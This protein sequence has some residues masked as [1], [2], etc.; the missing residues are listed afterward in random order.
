MTN[1]GPPWL[2]RVAS[3]KDGDRFGITKKASNGFTAHDVMLPA[4]ETR[5]D[6][7]P[8]T[9]LIKMSQGDACLMIGKH[10][11][12]ADTRD[13]MFLS[14][15]KCP[16]FLMAHALGR[17]HT[18][19]WDTNIYFI[20]IRKATRLD[21]RPAGFIPTS[22]LVDEFGVLDFPG[23]QDTETRKRNHPRK[24]TQEHVVFG[25]LGYKDETTRSALVSELIRDGLYEIFPTFEVDAN[26]SRSGLYESQVAYRIAGFPAKPK[27]YPAVYS[28][29]NCSLPCDIDLYLLETVRKVDLNR[30]RIPAG[31]DINTIQPPVH[32]VLPCCLSKSVQ[33]A[34]QFSRAS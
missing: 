26:H 11:Q 20:E 4:A 24:S 13:D 6:E 16:M 31:A 23:F 29:E 14:F 10:I 25:A 21:G 30:V 3:R 19:Q 18:G 17:Y 32:A 7:C 15:S 34:T 5:P 27:D 1:T 2:G 8:Y 22:T 33:T 9:Q 28:Y 12:W